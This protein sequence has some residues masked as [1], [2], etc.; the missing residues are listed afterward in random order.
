M[1]AVMALVVLVS[2]RYWPLRRIEQELPDAVG[3]AI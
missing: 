1:G 2:Y 3:E